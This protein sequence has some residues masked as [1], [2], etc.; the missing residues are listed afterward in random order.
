LSKANK[1]YTSSDFQQ[2]ENL[3]DHGCPQLK[4]GIDFKAMGLTGYYM[5]V[6]PLGQYPGMNDRNHPNRIRTI[7][8]SVPPGNDE[9]PVTPRS[10]D[11]CNM[12]PSQ[13][14]LRWEMK[15]MGV[16]LEDL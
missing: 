10:T 2:N 15:M 9:I 3:L 11:N 1:K 8:P 13:P 5:L 4:E 16:T 12:L 7:S 14:H 6:L